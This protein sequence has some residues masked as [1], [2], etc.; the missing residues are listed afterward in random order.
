MPPKSGEPIT[1][2]GELQRIEVPQKKPFGI[3]K[4]RWQILLKRIN[5]PFHD[6]SNIVTVNNLCIIHGDVFDMDWAKEAKMEM[7]TYANGK[8]R[9]FQ[10]NKMF[11]IAF[12]VIKQMKGLQISIVI[13]EDVANN[14][15]GSND[16]K[17]MNG[18][19]QN[20]RY[21]YIIKQMLVKLQ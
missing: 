19:S 16:D 2:S 18:G 8:F 11:H 13:I 7:Q 10:N 5:M 15:L 6:L 3:L 1:Q 4:S 21:T 20:Y 14:I 12:N 9:D 17:V